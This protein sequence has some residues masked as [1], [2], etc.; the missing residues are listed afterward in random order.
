ML[1]TI[2]DHSFV[3]EGERYRLVEWDRGGER[4]IK[5]D[6]AMA[7]APA[8]SVIE[9]IDGANLYAEAVARE[10]LREAPDIFWE[11]RVLAP[12]QNGTTTRSVMLDKVPRAL[13]EQFR[14]EVD[15]FVSLIF[16]PPAVA[17]E[18]APPPGAGEPV[19]V[20]PA[21]ALSPV[22]RGRAE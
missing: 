17:S 12:T 21:Q 7:I 13:W 4:R 16:P 20:A 11:A 9:S 10:C 18:P 22:L 8:P 2:I 15:H 3:L 19:A 1:P 5:A 14:K 6:Y